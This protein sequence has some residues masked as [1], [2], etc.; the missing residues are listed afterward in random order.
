MYC[1]PGQIVLT[2]IVCSVKNKYDN[3]HAA[4]IKSMILEFYHE[5]E[6]FNAKQVLVQST[7]DIS[8]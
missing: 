8:L 4:V 6:I 5:D 3:N 2:D 7:S 1:I